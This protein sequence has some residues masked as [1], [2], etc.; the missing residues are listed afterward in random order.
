MIP[1]LMARPG[2]GSVLDNP[3]YGTVSIPKEAAIVFPANSRRFMFVI[4]NKFKQLQWLKILIRIIA[5][6]PKQTIFHFQHSTT[7]GTTLIIQN[8]GFRSALP[9]ATILAAALRLDL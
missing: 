1:F 9:R 6:R 8:P 2:S 7:D 3:K 5:F 4:L